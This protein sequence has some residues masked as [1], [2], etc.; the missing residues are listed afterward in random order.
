[1][2][3]NDAWLAEVAG[4]TIWPAA[5]ATADP[6]TLAWLPNE[7]I[8]EAWRHYVKDTAIPDTT[9]PPSPTNVRIDGNRMSWSCNA[10][11]ESG[12][13]CFE[14]ELNGEVIAQVPEQPQ[15]RFGRPL[16]QNLLYSDTPTQPLAEMAFSLPTPPAGASYGVIAVNTVGLKSAPTAI[17]Y[18]P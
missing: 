6:L 14:I 5:E 4:F 1:M 8:A 10:D 7:Q 15:N 11:L 12:L 9:P 2:P 13:A 16:F 17:L 3:T 18:Q